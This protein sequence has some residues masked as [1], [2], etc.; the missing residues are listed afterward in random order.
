RNVTGVQTCALPIYSCI[1]SNVSGLR[2]NKPLTLDVMQE[3]RGISLKEAQANLGYDIFETPIDFN[4]ERKL[5][6]KEV[7]QVFRYCENDVLTT[8]KLFEKREDYFTS[9]F[10]V[11]QEF[12]LPVTSLKKTRAN[13]A[14]EVLK[15]R[16]GT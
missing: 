10:E 13:L 12:K 16:K 15:A 3:L 1:T 4:I 6:K 2:L 5:M 9:K 11:V 14:S 8:K 7:K